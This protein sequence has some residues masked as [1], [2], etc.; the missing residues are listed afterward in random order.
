MTRIP[1]KGRRGGF[2]RKTCKF[3]PAVA[4]YR[5]VMKVSHTAEHESHYLEL[6][7]RNRD[8]ISRICRSWTRTREDFQ[9]LRSEVFLALWRSLPSFDG[10]SSQDSWLYRVTLNTAL[11]HARTRRRRGGPEVGFD[12][13]S[14]PSAAPDVASR[15]EESER[16]RLLRTA[17]D[18]LGGVDRSL[19]TLWLEELSYRQIAEVTG[20]SENHVGVALHRARKKLAQLITKEEASHGSR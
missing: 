14:E 9:D 10:R 13:A 4:T 1:F 8:R 20:L 18:R 16:W 15:L 19:I 11:F 12:E 7:R 3:P 6:V 17:L 2:L 5:D